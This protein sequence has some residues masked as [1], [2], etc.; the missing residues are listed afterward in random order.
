MAKGGPKATPLQRNWNQESG[1]VRQA[2]VQ[3]RIERDF[4]VTERSAKWVTDITTDLHRGGLPVPVRGGR[5][6]RRQVDGLSISTTLDRS[7]VLQAFEPSLPNAGRASN[8]LAAEET[9]T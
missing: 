2:D 8:T 7:L 1:G 6:L 9:T 5:S 4:T 3:N